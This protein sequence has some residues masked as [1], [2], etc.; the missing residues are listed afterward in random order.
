MLFFHALDLL[1]MFPTIISFSQ[2]FLSLKAYPIF[3]S[4]IF[5]STII[6]MLESVYQVIEGL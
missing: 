2:S 1:Q 5:L 4:V 6:K 3:V